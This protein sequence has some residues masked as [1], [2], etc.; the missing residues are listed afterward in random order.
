MRL[1]KTAIALLGTLVLTQGK[2]SANTISQAFSFSS[3]TFQTF[4]N[5]S[6]ELGYDFTT[7]ANA[8]EVAALGYIND[9]FNGTH[10]ISI[11]DVA[12]ETLVP[13]ATAVVTTVGGRFHE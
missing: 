1:W 9:G 2:A 4:D 10:T 3:A 11:F 12:N 7:G 8:I 5:A 13:G 6:A